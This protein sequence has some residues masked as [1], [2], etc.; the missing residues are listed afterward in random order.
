MSFTCLTIVTIGFCLMDQNSKRERREMRTNWK[1]KGWRGG[2]DNRIRC[3]FR[4]EECDRESR[5]QERRH[6][7]PRGSPLRVLRLKTRKM[8][9]DNEEGDEMK[10][11]KPKIEMLI[12]ARRTP[13][14]IS[15][16]SCDSNRMREK[17][18][19]DS[20]T[21]CLWLSAGFKGKRRLCACV[22]QSQSS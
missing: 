3:K 2:Q 21:D 16:F 14:L 15:T 4:I 1:R 6:S 19:G 10:S 5:R 20:A 9:N 17:R 11:S 7:S 13:F 22:F 12:K 8:R 18:M